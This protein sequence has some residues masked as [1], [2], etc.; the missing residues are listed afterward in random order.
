MAAFNFNFLTMDITPKTASPDDVLA[1]L[2]NGGVRRIHFA[3]THCTALKIKEN[4]PS[5]LNVP[6]T[7]S[8]EPLL[9]SEVSGFNGFIPNKFG[10]YSCPINDDSILSEISNFIEI[11]KNRV[12]LKDTLD[13]S[14]ALDMNMSK[15]G[16][17]T[18]VGELEHEAKENNDENALKKLAQI[19]DSFISS[20]RLYKT[21]DFVCAMPSHRGLPLRLVR[22]LEECQARDISTHVSWNKD[23]IRGIEEPI[24]K[25]NS[26]KNTSLNISDE[27]DLNDKTIIIIDD[28]YKSGATA[29]HLGLEFKKKGAKFVYGLFLVKSLAY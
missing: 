23:A 22:S 3:S 7:D 1:L 16:E 14:V 26:L 13:L 24:D 15:P 19:I 10:S 8:I 28:L 12:F 9:K 18:E 27:L 21:A 17:Y 2:K 25:Y 11:N 4:A 5:W 6:F 29:M 20:T